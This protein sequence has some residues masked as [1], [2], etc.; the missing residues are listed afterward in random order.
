VRFRVDE[1][2][3]VKVRV[4]VR[5]AGRRSGSRCVKPTRAN[6]RARACFRY[7]FVGSAALKGT[8]SGLVSRRFS[9]RI[10]SR[11]L[12]PGAYRLEVVATDRAG[13]R[14]RPVTATFRIARG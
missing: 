9:G 2:S 14:S 4:L 11:A 5:S 12:K 6:R 7:L 10:G 1:A 8:V 3:T 13:N